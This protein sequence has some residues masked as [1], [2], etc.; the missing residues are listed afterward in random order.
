[1]V[2]KDVPK[3]NKLCNVYPMGIINVMWRYIMDYGPLGG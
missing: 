2:F 3:G 1:M